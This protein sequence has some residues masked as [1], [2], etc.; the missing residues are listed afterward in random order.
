MR[1]SMSSAGIPAISRSAISRYRCA[2][3][4]TTIFPHH[5]LGVLFVVSGT[6]NM[7]EVEQYGLWSGP[8][9]Y[10]S[11]SAKFI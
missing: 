1:W 4:A 5:T 6:G 10:L 2:N 9:W 8:R 11:R 7:R 3:G